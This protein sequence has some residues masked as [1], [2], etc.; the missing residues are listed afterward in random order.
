MQPLSLCGQLLLNWCYVVYPLPHGSILVQ[1]QIDRS[2][3]L[4][5]YSSMSR[6]LVATWALPGMYV[7]YTPEFNSMQVAIEVN[8]QCR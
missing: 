8:V 2:V 1:T 6:A 5:P 3:C 7:P 4:F